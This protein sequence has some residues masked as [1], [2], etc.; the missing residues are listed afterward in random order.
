[1]DVEIE[2]LLL[3]SSQE[4]RNQGAPFLL[5]LA[6]TPNLRSQLG[7]MNS[8]F[9][10]RCKAI[11]VGRLSEAAT[12]QALLVPLSRYGVTFEE[13]V[14]AQVVTESQCYPYFIQI[15]G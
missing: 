14:L 7:K 2:Q 4:A 15:W 13:D 3:N 10:S 6:G 5:V 12:R 9:W 11:G 1:M 8:S